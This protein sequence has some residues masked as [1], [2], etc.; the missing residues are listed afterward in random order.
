MTMTMIVTLYLGHVSVLKLV[1]PSPYTVVSLNVLSLIEALDVLLIQN[2]YIAKS[3]RNLIVLKMSLKQYSPV[4]F[5]I[6]CDISLF[7]SLK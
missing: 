6:P 2:R 3:L 1:T 7:C 5:A 4:L